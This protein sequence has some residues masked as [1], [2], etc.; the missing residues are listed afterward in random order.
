MRTFAALL[1]VVLAASPPPPSAAGGGERYAWPLTI[2]NGISSMFQEFRDNHFH[3]GI[4]LRTFQRTGFP[5]LAIA[6]GVIESL[7]VSYRGYGRSLRLRHADGRRSLYGHLE[8]FRDDIEALA[9]RQQERCGEKYFGV[10]VLPAPLAVRRGEVIAFSGESGSGF[11]HLHLEIRDGQDRAL[12]P[13]AFLDPPSTD[14]Q[15]PQ[16]RGVL[17]RSLGGSL[18]NGDCGA[19]YFKLR[20]HGEEYALS[21][22]LAIS[23]PCDVTIDAVDLSNVRYLVAPYRLEARLDGRTAFQVSFDRLTRDDNNQLGML[24]DMAHSTADSYFFNLYAQEGF[25]LEKSGVGMAEELGRLPPGLHE[26]RITVADYQGNLARA[27][28]PI[29]KLVGGDGSPARAKPPAED[30]SGVMRRTEIIPFVNRGDIVVKLQDVGVPAQ[31]LALR[32][33]QGGSERLFSAREY[34]RGAYFCFQPLSSEP[35]LL[36]RYELSAGGQTVEMRQ[37]ALQAVLLKNHSAQSVRFGDFEA[38]FGPTSVREPTVLLFERVALRPDYPLL[39]GPVRLEPFHFTFLDAV[40]FKFRVAAG[41]ERREQMGI[42]RRHPVSGKWISQPTQVDREP[43]FLSC[44]V[45]TAG[46]YALLRDEF[47]PQIQW[48]RPRSGKR[49]HWQR[50]VIRIS[51]KGKGVDERTIAVTL[52][53]TRLD[54][55]YDPDWKHVRLEMPSGLRHGRNELRVRAADRAGNVS[56]RRFSFFLE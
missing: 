12:N 40:F 38:D 2:D 51:D 4:D 22:P 16:L 9:A 14:G 43:G 47:P 46:T 1:L 13:L 5:V 28:L 44:R 11:P 42:F 15:A 55:E 24:Y 41:A 54:T 48:R 23:G 8:R 33:I 6:D 21:E 17:L 29:L 39:A 27:V 52:N 10:H 37:Q 18:V 50:Q 49:T 25:T 3:A 34:A 32:V 31:R 36:L 26:L 19:F 45:L 20:R 30:G 7:S 53:G 35:R 56:E